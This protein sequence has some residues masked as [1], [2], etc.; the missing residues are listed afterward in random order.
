MHVYSLRTSVTDNT[1]VCRQVEAISQ[2][3]CPPLITTFGFLFFCFCFFHRHI[4]S[5]RRD[6]P[7]R[8]FGEKVLSLFYLCFLLGLQVCAS[9]SGHFTGLS[10]GSKSALYTCTEN[11][12]LIVLHSWLPIDSGFLNF[13]NTST[14]IYVFF[15]TDYLS[16]ITWNRI[17]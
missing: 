10:A 7:N 15:Y 9:T 11:N 12:F 3:L 13:I 6:L 1:W 14:L 2:S 8:L 17:Y 4:S 16:G 5:L